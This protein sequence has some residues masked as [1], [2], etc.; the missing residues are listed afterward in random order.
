MIKIIQ[1]GSSEHKDS[2]WNGK[3]VAGDQ[4]GSEVCVRDYY[5]Y[6]WDY[7]LRYYDSSVSNEVIENAYKLANAEILGYDQS[8]RNTLYQKLSA[9]RFNVDSYIKSGIKTE[10]DCSAFVYA[11]FCTKIATMR[12][13]ANAPTTSTMRSYYSRRGFTV[14]P[15]KAAVLKTGD[16]LLAEGNHTALV[17]IPH[18]DTELDNALT[19]IA[20]EVLKGTFGNMPERKERIYK[21]IQS[22][23]ND[24]LK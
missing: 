24:I 14:Y 22:K 17:Y 16:I 1:A 13:N 3:A 19:V 4:T 7:V 8:E 6:P 18:E 15:I 10:T 21:M 5:N 2:G 9:Y 23:V 12:S 11:C 20:K